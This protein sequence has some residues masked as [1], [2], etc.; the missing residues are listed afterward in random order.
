MASPTTFLVQLGGNPPGGPQFSG[1]WHRWGSSGQE[2]CLAY[3]CGVAMTEGEVHRA[4]ELL[5]QG[6]AESVFRAHTASMVVVDP[7]AGSAIIAC[8]PSGMHPLFLH[9][10]PDGL[11]VGNSLAEVGGSVRRPDF[12][13][14]LEHLFWGWCIGTRTPVAGV[15]RLEPGAVATIAAGPEGPSI[16]WASVPWHGTPNVEKPGTDFW[17]HLTEA[18]SVPVSGPVALMMSG[19]WDSRTVLAAL[20]QHVSPDRILLYSHGMVE[21]RELALVKAIGKRLGCKVHLEPITPGSFDLSVMAEGFH[22]TGHIQFPYWHY[23]GHRL[24]D[25]GVGQAYAG[26]LGEVVGG[27]YGTTFAGSFLQKA[28]A[29]V[30]P[31]LAKPSSGRGIVDEIMARFEV[32]IPRG[33]PWFLTSGAWSL[34]EPSVATIR[35]ETRAWM[36]RGLTEANPTMGGLMEEFFAKHRAGHYTGEQPRCFMGVLPWRNPMAT[37]DCIRSGVA[38]DFSSRVQNRH[39]RR[40]LLKHDRRV[41]ERPTAACLVPAKYPIPIQEASRALRKVLE[42]LSPTKALRLSW[43]NFDFLRNSGKLEIIAAT[44]GPD[45]IDREAVQQRIARANASDRGSMHSLTDMLLKITNAEWWLN[46]GAIGAG[47]NASG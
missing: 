6:D 21:S 14:L 26:V 23:A 24:V 16:K 5:V 3:E 45:I 9:E 34:A 43:A 17:A 13:G 27:G 35:E 18:I 12:V 10:S 15:Q 20:L 40:M 38:L 39:N 28:L 8:H 25:L 19:G 41:L 29:T 44:F 46:P 2:R 11:V 1:S 31:R 47:R 7:V 30:T 4:G 33:K 32:N 22:R 37:L 36:E 42:M